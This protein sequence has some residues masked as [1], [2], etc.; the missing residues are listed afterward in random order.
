MKIPRALE[1]CKTT[2]R[3]L[4]SI[5]RSQP[6]FGRWANAET[7]DPTW[8]LRTRAIARLVPKE[9]RVIEFGSG[10]ELLQSYL[11]PTC[12]YVPVDLVPRSSQTLVADL[13]K[14]PLPNLELRDTDVI[15]FGGV[16]E[17]I[18]R[19]P[20]IP[21][22]LRGGPS[23]CIA[24]YECVSTKR[25]TANRFSEILARMKNGWRNHYTE[26]QLKDIF[27]TGGFEFVSKQKWGMPGD[28]GYI[29]V[30]RKCSSSL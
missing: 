19:L 24:S 28:E 12:S 30:F 27:R 4:L 5:L 22:W 29:F 14:R 25:Y 15:V 26:E 1:D 9:T 6:D 16:L 17:Y 20:D 21:S 2:L 3:A 10:R 7:F 23:L 11:D 13:N 8:D 18:S